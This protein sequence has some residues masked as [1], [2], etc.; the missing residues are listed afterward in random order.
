MELFKRQQQNNGTQTI[1]KNVR[2]L[3]M[4][5][6]KDAKSGQ[7]DTPFFQPTHAHA[8]RAFKTEVNRAADNNT[9]YLYPEDFELYYLGEFNQLD[10]EMKAV[11]ELIG[12]GPQ[13]KA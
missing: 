5:V 6:I 8:M 10:G 13:F 11:N 4:Y 9:I 12:K 1:T 3:Q 2:T 7:Y